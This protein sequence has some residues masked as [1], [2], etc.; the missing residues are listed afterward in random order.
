MDYALR[1]LAVNEEV[2]RL[3]EL[4]VE[5]GAIPRTHWEDALHVAL[6][7][8]NEMD[9]LLSWNFK[10]LSNIKKQVAVRLVNEQ[11]NY[12]Y[13]LMLTNPMEVVYEDF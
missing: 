2:E 6:A 1:E 10:H 5:S 3:A 13:P 8:I 12:F 9:L 7:T 11:N 4:Y